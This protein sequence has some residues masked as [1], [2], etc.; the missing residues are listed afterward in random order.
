MQDAYIKL[1]IG[2]TLFATW[3]SLVVFQVP[4]VDDII[5]AIKLALLGLGAYHLDRSSPQ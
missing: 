1:F 3:I 4:H 5:T 2:M